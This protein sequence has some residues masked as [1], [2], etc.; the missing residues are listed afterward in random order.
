[1]LNMRGR[2]KHKWDSLRQVLAEKIV[3]DDNNI[4]VWMAPDGS[5]QGLLYY[6]KQ[7]QVGLISAQDLLGDSVSAVC[8][9]FCRPAGQN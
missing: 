4:R 1:M 3:Y 2:H 6:A 7:A 5:G 8:P 9:C